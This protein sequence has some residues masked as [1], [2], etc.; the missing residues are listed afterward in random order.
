MS[1]HIL[2][3]GI[4]FS[5]F[6]D[7]CAFVDGPNKTAKCQYCGKTFASVSGRQ[8]HEKETHEGK[9]FKCSHCS[10]SFSRKE[11][12]DQHYISEHQSSTF[13]CTDCEQSFNNHRKLGRHKK[14]KH[15]W[16]PGLKCWLCGVSYT[17]YADL[18]RHKKTIQHTRKQKLRRFKC[19]TCDAEFKRQEHLLR[20]SLESHMT[21]E[22]EKIT[23]D[24]CSSTFSRIEH[25]KR[26]M[27]CLHLKEPNR[28]SCNICEKQYSRQ[29]NL[30]RHMK[31]VHMGKRFNCKDC[32]AKFVR[33]EDL[34]KHRKEGN[35][36]WELYC[37]FCKQDLI[38]KTEEDMIAHFRYLQWCGSS[39]TVSPRKL[40]EFP[41]FCVNEIKNKPP[42]MP[43]DYQ[44]KREC[45]VQGCKEGGVREKEFPS[46]IARNYHMKIVHNMQV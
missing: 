32:P 43:H 25:W 30:E 42:D 40:P 46:R 33:N 18:K 41:D 36:Y 5:S 6:D 28:V 39:S 3:K 31:S 29:D 27:D 7:F 14:V 2:R 26:H 20:H 8:R 13:D 1:D 21:A 16:Q 12:R 37:T 9:R 17:K 11:R 35:H 34:L 24:Y 4:K 44:Q 10:S 15:N 45:F 22:E 23:C 38:F 19:Q